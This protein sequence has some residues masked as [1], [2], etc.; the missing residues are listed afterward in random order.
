VSQRRRAGYVFEIHE[1]LRRRA[2]L[3]DPGAAFA[4]VERQPPRR[5]RAPAFVD[6][7][8]RIYFGWSDVIEATDDGVY[9]VTEVTHGD[10][11]LKIPTPN[12]DEYF[13]CEVRLKKGFERKLTKGEER[14]RFDV[15]YRRERKSRV[16]PQSAVRFRQTPRAE[17]V[18]TISATPSVP[19]ADSKKYITA[20]VRSGNSGRFA[21]ARGART[22]SSIRATTPRRRRSIRPFTAA[23]RVCRIR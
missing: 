6:P 19:A 11:I 4:H 22:R 17:V 2:A 3:A 9:T 18:A 5:R 13:L 7:Y 20:T 21:T 15:A 23:R 14:A 10:K 12:P 16:V 1:R 8:Q